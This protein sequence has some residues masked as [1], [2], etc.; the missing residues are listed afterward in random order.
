M[1]SK[2]VVLIFVV[3]AFGALT[4]NSFAQ[5]LK[6]RFGWGVG[7]GTQQLYSEPSVT[8][9]GFGG[10]GLLSYRLS[11][12]LSLNLAFGYNT[13]G[14]QIAATGGGT[15]TKTTNLVYGDLL[16][17]YELMSKSSF[18]PFVTTG[19]GG[20]NFLHTELNKRYNDAEFLLGGGLRFFLSP[21][22]ALSLSSVAKYTTGDDLDGGQRGTTMKDIY[23]QVRTGFTMYMGPKTTVK[24]DNLFTENLD[25][26]QLG[27]ENSDDGFFFEEDDASGENTGALF[28]EDD[29]G[30]K[31][32]ES[33]GEDYQ[34]FLNRLN[35]MDDSQ[36]AAS[37]S[38]SATTM[39]GSSNPKM[40]EYIR[41]KSRIDELNAT[42]EKKE[43]EI[44]SIQQ[45]LVSKQNVNAVASQTVLRD[46]NYTASTLGSITN[47]SKAYE[48]ALMK[49][50][51]RRYQE[52]VDLFQALLEKYPDHALSS[53]CEY[54]I[55]ESYFAAGNFERAITSFQK[56]LQ[57]EKSLKK[58]DALLM[59]GR[60]YV[61]LGNKSEAQNAFNRLIREFPASEF[62]PKSE[63]YLRK[64]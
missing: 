45:A 17:D 28:A 63:Q 46:N 49:F 9:F 37:S 13:L 23:F 34:D 1:T 29:Q 8:P 21:T 4:T 55:G 20:L 58:D 30:S 25:V 53:N 16:L 42:I 41:L 14:F 56:V 3:A 40:E 6:G 52:A 60:A 33:G 11:N 15:T 35:E 61:E 57:Y 31:S 36:P 48:S 26:E 12:A 5:G 24:D 59:I 2:R 50:Y 62:V 32:A 18:R 22:M 64:L 10:N 54:W 27:D 39:A 51:S 19:I 44:Y 38:S 43:T 47:Y 7:L